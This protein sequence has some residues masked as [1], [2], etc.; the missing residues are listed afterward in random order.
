MGAF[1]FSS[2][3]ETQGIVL[4]EAMAAGIPVVALD[5][6]GVREVVKDGQ[7]GRLLHE[8]TA[9]SFAAAL[10][11]LSMRPPQE[12]RRLRWAARETAEAFSMSRCAQR[13]LEAYAEV[14]A[15]S[16]SRGED[17]NGLWHAALRRAR[18]EWD[19]YKIITRATGAALHLTPTAVAHAVN[20][21]EGA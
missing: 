7:N 20:G 8:E 21:D 12:Q 9:A 16:A 2:K 10:Q 1:A 18:A 3:S 5:A 11:W 4:V 14:R 19:V 15:R 13:A 6:S 17:G